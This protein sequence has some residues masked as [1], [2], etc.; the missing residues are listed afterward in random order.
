MKTLTA[1]CLFAIAAVAAPFASA[2][3]AGAGSDLTALREANKSAAAKKAHVESALDL[4]AAERRKF[5]PVYDAH[6]R[7]LDA[8]NRRYNRAIEDMIAVGT[9]KPVTDAYAKQVAAEL[10]AV[11][12]A[13]ARAMR[14]MH[15]AMMKAVAPRVALRYMQIE[16][17]LQAVRR[18]D[19]ALGL[20]LV[21]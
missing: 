11:Q 1:V 19:V 15:N 16:N 21:R 2:Q 5:W 12:E 18:A 8:N 14:A 3:P 4:S 20:S 10:V 17:R 13:D 6:Q 7:K 9:D